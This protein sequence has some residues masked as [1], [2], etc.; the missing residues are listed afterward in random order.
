MNLLDLVETLDPEATLAFFYTAIVAD[1]PFENGLGAECGFSFGV[2][3]RPSTH[4][5]Q[6]G[7]LSR[8]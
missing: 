6:S 5:A 1:L 4:H 3:R 8:A 7:R 2:D